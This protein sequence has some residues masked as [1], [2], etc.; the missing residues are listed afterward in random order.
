METPVSERSVR[1]G[2]KIDRTPDNVIQRDV[3]EQ[4]R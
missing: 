4:M 2:G 3:K 1:A